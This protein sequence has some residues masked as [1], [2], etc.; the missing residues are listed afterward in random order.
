MK[1]LYWPQWYET[2]NYLHEEIWI[3]HKYVEFKQYATEQQMGQRKIKGEIFKNTLRQKKMEI[4]YTKNLWDTAKAV[5]R[6]KFLAINGLPQE[7][8]KV[9]NNLTLYLKELEKEQMKPRI[10]RREDIT[11]VG[12]K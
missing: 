8:R 12:Q 10:S 4:A 7:T 11:N 1:H 6:G 5:L 9:T 2:G 3:I